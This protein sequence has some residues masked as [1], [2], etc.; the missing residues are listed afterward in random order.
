MFF[1]PPEQSESL[2]SLVFSQTQTNINLKYQIFKFFMNNVE[3]ELITF[4]MSLERLP[5]FL[6]NRA[7][8]LLIGQDFH[9]TLHWINF[10]VYCDEEKTVNALRHHFTDSLPVPT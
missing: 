8:N 4:L 5:C 9:L 1:L 7:V 2:M 10:F 3:F 6:R